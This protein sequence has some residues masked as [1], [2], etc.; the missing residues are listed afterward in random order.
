M[1]AQKIASELAQSYASEVLV[2][3]QKLEKLTLF[4]F[5]I[6]ADLDDVLSGDAE[7][8]PQ[9]LL[10]LRTKLDLEVFDDCK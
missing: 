4:L 6:S 9:M 7:E 5:D 8:V 2:L 10:G 1:N 3:R